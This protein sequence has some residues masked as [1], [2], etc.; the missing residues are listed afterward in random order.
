MENGNLNAYPDLI[1]TK[2]NDSEIYVAF[3][4][5]QKSPSR[6]K[7][8]LDEHTKWLRKGGQIYWITPTHKHSPIEFNAKSTKMTLKQKIKKS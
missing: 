4:R 1:I 6:F 2:S 3:E 8:K 7:K 5:T